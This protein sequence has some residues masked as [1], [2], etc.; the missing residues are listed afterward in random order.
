PLRP[1]FAQQSCSSDSF[2]QNRRYTLCNSLPE[3]SGKLHWSYHPSNSTVDV[4]YRAPQSADGWIA[5]ALN[6][7]GSGMVGAQV[8]FAFHDSS[9]VMTAISYPISNT[10]PSVRNTSLSYRVYSMTSE[11]NNNMMTIYATIE[12]P[13]NRTQVNHVWQASNLFTNGAPNGH[14]LNGPNVQS[15][16]TLD[17]LSGELSSGGVPGSTLRM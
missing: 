12:L 3:L 5:W 15:Y 7:T 17:L 11:F 9:S 8:I 4:A 16:G 6:P 14:P 1:A 2:T 10:S 13:Q